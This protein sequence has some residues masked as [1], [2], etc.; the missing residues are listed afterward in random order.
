MTPRDREALERI[1]ECADAINAYVE[2][3]GDNWCVA[4]RTCSRRRP[5]IEQVREAPRWAARS[6]RSWTTRQVLL[7][8]PGAAALPRGRWLEH[9]LR[10]RRW[11]LLQYLLGDHLHYLVVVVLS[12][13][14]AVLNAYLGYRYVV[15]RSRGPVLRELPRFSLVYLVDARREPRAAARRPAG[16]AVQHLRGPG[17]LH[18][19]SWSSAAT[20]ATSTTAS[21][22][23]IA[24]TPATRPRTIPLPY[25]RIDRC[26]TAERNRS[27]SAD[28]PHPCFNEE[29]NVRE[30]Y[31]QVKAAME[32][33]PGYDYEHLFID[34]ASKDRTVEILRELA[35][36]DKRVKVI[37]NT[38]NFGHIR[39][40]YH[41]FLQARGDAVM[42]CVADLQDPPGA[43]PPVRQEVGGGLQGRH[44]REGGQ[45]GILAHV[46][47][48]EVLL[49]ARRQAL[50]GRGARP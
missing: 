6:S 44:R 31:Q 41:A 37:V 7:P 20:W 5:D 2:R 17:A 8:P 32:T 25:R 49:L 12:W 33:V 30:V 22:A 15:F 26:P 19:R 29:G 16:A 10:V 34:N 27:A 18:R 28:D 38:R 40:P 35:A 39:S 9:G 50:I 23:D 43:H 36:A 45:P 24:E 1:I 14:I 21:A 3:A 46:S 47:H 13:P 11:A 42:S 4:W 48:A